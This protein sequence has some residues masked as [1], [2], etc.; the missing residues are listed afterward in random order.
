MG[1]F[2]IGVAVGG[3]ALIA[4]AALDETTKITQCE[5]SLPRTQYCRLIAV[6]NE[7]V[8]E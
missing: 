5:K 2:I 7:E 3:C 8:R 6:P 1:N 4:L